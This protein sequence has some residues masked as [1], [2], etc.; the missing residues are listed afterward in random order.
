MKLLLKNAG[1]IVAACFALAAAT[2]QA[3]APTLAWTRVA[4]YPHAAQDFTQG[5]VYGEGR[6]F[7][8]A[9]QYGASRITEKDLAS[10][11]VLRA[12]KLPAAEFGEGLALVNNRLWQL[13]WREGRAHSYDLALRRQN[14][15]RYQGE[16][17]GLTS[18]GR[19]LLLSDGSATIYFIDPRDFSTVSKIQVRDGARPIANLNELEWVEGVLYANVWLSNR[20]A[21]ID[22]A[23]GL[24]T[25]WLDFSALVAE[26]G[27]AP[28]RLAAG[29][30]L[31]GLAW[32]ADTRHL[33]VTGKWWPKLFE[34]Q[35]PAP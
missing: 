19:Q 5:L 35:L 33:L 16:G 13:T 20:V 9:G 6:L 4:S 34:V 32:R 27:V 11:R 10:G 2:A 30:V 15:L 26:A 24:V 31:N 8:S 7:E 14:S 22:P 21:R 17:W 23:S 3:E 29:A 18:D 25:G 28:E 1:R 12:R